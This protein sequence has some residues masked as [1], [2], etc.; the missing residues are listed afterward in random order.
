MERALL[1]RQ[2]ARE[3][4]F[5]R[6]NRAVEV[7]PRVIP[8]PVIHC[9]HCPL[10]H[11]HTHTVAVTAQEGRAFDA[12]VGHYMS[13]AQAKEERQ[14]RERHEEWRK[15]VAAPIHRSVHAML[16]SEVGAQPLASS[17]CVS[18]GVTAAVSPY[19]R[20]S[21]CGGARASG[22]A[23]TWRGGAASGRSWTP[24]RRRRCGTLPGCA[25]QWRLCT[26]TPPFAAWSSRPR[27]G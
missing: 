17:P 27:R 6:L 26:G 12:E 18:D 7:R 5:E 19:R 21:S 16:S 9:R 14:Q 22:T 25:P 10:T 2:E 4:E 11:T 24:P 23:T 15:E 8:S 13:V 1:Q 20:T 3:A